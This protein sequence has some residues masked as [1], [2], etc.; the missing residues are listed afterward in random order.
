MLLLHDLYRPDND[1]KE[2]RIDF[3][4]NQN[5]ATEFLAQQEDRNILGS[6]TGAHSGRYEADRGIMLPYYIDFKSVYNGLHVPPRVFS[7]G[8]KPAKS[9]AGAT[10]KFVISR[11]LSTGLTRDQSQY[12]KSFFGEIQTRILFLVFSQYYTKIDL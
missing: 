4:L 3:Q 11:L 1:C 12:K 8:Q 5:D 9:C 10:N 7:L 6:V 2:L